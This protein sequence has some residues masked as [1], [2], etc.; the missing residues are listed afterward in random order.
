[1]LQLR[2]VEAVTTS[3][4]G[5]DYVHPNKNL[6]V[7]ILNP[8]YKL[9][10]NGTTFTKGFRM[11]TGATNG[12]VLTSNGSGA[13]AWRSLSSLGANNAAGSNTWFQFNDNGIFGGNGALSLLTASKTLVVAADAPLDINSTNVS[14]ADTN[15]SLDGASTTFT[16]TTGAIT[17]QPASGS[18][19]NV[20]L[21]TTGD[22][23]VN[24]N[25]L[26]VDTSATNV[27]I[28]TSTP[29]EKLQVAGTVQSTGLKMTTGAANNYILT[30]DA[31]GLS[32]WTNPNSI[33]IGTS[34]NS[35]NLDTLD[36]TQFLRSDTS[37][38]FTSGTLTTLNGTTLKVNGDF[39]LRE[40]SAP[41]ASSGFGKLFVNAASSNLFFLDDSGASYDLLSALSGSAPAAGSNT[42]FQFND[43]GILGGNGALTFTKASKTLTVDATAPLDINSTALSIADSNI[44][45][46]G[47][48]TTFAQSN[49]GFAFDL[50]GSGDFVVEDSR[51]IADSNGNVG[52]NTNNPQARLD[53]RDGGGANERGLQLTQS[54]NDI[55]SA[56]FSMKKSRG[57]PGAPSIV[58]NGDTISYL[59]F[60]PFNG[61]GF[62]WTAGLGA[63]VRGTVTGTSI[64]TDLFFSTSGGG[65]DYNPFFSNTVRMLIDSTGNIG[66]GTT[67][68][69][70]KLTINGSAPIVSIREGSS[71]ASTANF[72][73]LFVSSINSQLYFR[74]DAGVNYNLTNGSNP[75]VPGGLNTYFQYNN[76]GSFGG[77]DAL[78]FVKGTKTL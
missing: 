18:N 12:Y 2:A 28:G 8:Q 6:G 15:I 23:V 70:E 44:V 47:A 64:P 24:T 59:N 50:N 66:V 31:L 33:I 68:P 9:T 61:D 75:T 35:N 45:F 42:Q 40:K 5:F 69:N 77:S 21:A 20:T 57:T 78:S 51:L 1:M 63:R 36:S 14:I 76:G 26:Y 30:S 17:M 10:V 11:Q 4:A 65:D 32:T 54:S 60:R 55:S 49:S 67:I 46:D 48:S 25:Q 37:D 52:I 53:I 62:M 19:L 29:A 74:D 41:T 73:K 13:A 58:S 38:Q 34:L 3:G 39:S 72:G 71:P 27:G 43:A 7:G 16:Q 22:F 56:I